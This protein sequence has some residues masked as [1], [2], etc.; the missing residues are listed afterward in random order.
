M[1][2]T[3]NGNVNIRIVDGLDMFIIS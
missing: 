1:A 2:R 3:G